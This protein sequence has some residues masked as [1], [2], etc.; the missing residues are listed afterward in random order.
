M[1]KNK[2]VTALNGFRLIPLN[3]NNKTMENIHKPIQSYLDL[4]P[5]KI[6][7]KARTVLDGVDNTYP[8]MSDFISDIIMR[9]NA[10]KHLWVTVANMHEL[11]ILV[12]V[13]DTERRLIEKY[14]EV[15]RNTFERANVANTSVN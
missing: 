3:Q 11:G 13:V 4:L 6:M 12:D 1:N 5:Y 10:N 15:I 2:L 7:V 9:D 8:S 14:N